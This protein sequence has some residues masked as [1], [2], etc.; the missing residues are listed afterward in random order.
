M[1]VGESSRVRV[2]RMGRIRRTVHLVTAIVALAWNARV[3]AQTDEI[4]VYDAQIAAPG[5][6]NLTLHDNYTPNGSS[7]AAHPGAIAPDGSWNG[8]AEWAYG[9]TPWFE[10]GL[11]FPLYSRLADRAIAYD[12]FKLRALFVSPDAA[13]RAVFYGVNFEFSFNTAHWNQKRYTSEI[14]PIIGTHV[15]RFDFIF[16]PILDN[17]YDGIAHLE[18]APETRVAMRVSDRVKLAVEEYDALGTITRFSPAS[19]R[20]H[21][22]FSVIDLA[23]RYVGIEFG[24][25]AGLNEATDHRV[26]KL[27]LTKDL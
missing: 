4:Q 20:S 9:V 25:G 3:A 15:G 21:Q 13:E 26:I 6:F 8:V 7:T 22:L 27:I 12:G 11:Y 1:S 2:I 10:A 14:R 24:I 16:N 17:S 19:K 5:V 18:F 23:T